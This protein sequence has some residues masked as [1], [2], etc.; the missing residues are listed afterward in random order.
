MKSS[1][2]GVFWFL[3][4]GSIQGS[5][6]CEICNIPFFVRH[7]DQET[8]S[9]LFKSLILHVFINTHNLRI[10]LPLGSDPLNLLVKCSFDKSC[11]QRNS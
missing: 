11:K 8:A 3:G 7:N 5:R 4:K 2:V 9:I 6:W 1:D 10:L